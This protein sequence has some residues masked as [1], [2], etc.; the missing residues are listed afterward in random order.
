M[1]KFVFNLQNV[2]NIKEKMEDQKKIELGNA[3]RELQFQQQKL[4]QLVIEKE[5][6]IN[7]FHKKKGTKIKARD[8]SKVNTAIKYYLDKITEQKELVNNAKNK[9]K[10]KREELKAAVVEKKTYE[11]LKEKALL[12]F[13]EEIKSEEN[14]I[15][16]EIVS[17]KYNS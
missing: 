7:E 2:L 12:D 16:D 13:M 8:L 17:Y 14:K 6:F 4:N 10:I 11:R 5:K 1:A 9:V 15:V 3:N